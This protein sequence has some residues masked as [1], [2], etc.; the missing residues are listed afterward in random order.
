MSESDGQDRAAGGV[1]ADDRDMP[2]QRTLAR[3]AVA[4]AFAALIAPVQR[5]ALPD[6]M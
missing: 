1:T 6:M 5:D 3:C 2:G 4:G